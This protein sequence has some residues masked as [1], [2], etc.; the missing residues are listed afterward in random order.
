MINPRQKSNGTSKSSSTCPKC[1]SQEY[2]RT[3]FRS[4]DPFLTRTFYK[5]YRCRKCRYRFF[6]I[7][8]LTV[9]WSS[10]I[11]GL[12]VLFFIAWVAQQFAE[13]E[14]SARDVA[15]YERAMERAKNGEGPAEL[16]VG[17]MLSEGRGVFKNDKEAA[18]WFKKGAQHGHLEAQYQYGNALFKGVGVLQ[19]YKDAIFWIEKAARAGHEKAQY[20]LGNIYRYKSGVEN[21]DKRA[22]LWFT[23]AAGQGSVEAA[24][25]RDQVE[26]RL[27]PEEIA[28]LQEE[29]GRIIKESK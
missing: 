18:E 5:A 4:N 13:P 19:N 22:Y 16:Q 3:T 14:L 8:T 24:I 2:R 1:D 28:A 26:G 27:R 10:I 12:S 21:D 7:N 23:L 9:T 20:D 17:M 11:A 15:A 29:A 6:L 25:A